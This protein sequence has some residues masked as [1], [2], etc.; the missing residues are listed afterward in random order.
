MAGGS[1]QSGVTENIGIIAGGVVAALVAMIVCVVA[2]CK[3]IKKPVSAAAN[4]NANTSISTRAYIRSDSQQQVRAV[5]LNYFARWFSPNAHVPQLYYPYPSSITADEYAESLPRYSNSHSH[6]YS[7]S[8][9]QDMQL[10]SYSLANRSINSRNPQVNPSHNSATSTT[11]TNVDT[12]NTSNP[13]RSGN[14]NSNTAD[15][16]LVA[17]HHPPLPFRSPPLSLLAKS[18]SHSHYRPSLRSAL[19]SRA[20]STSNLAAAVFGASSPAS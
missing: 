9:A 2:L 13:T 4:A 18:N 3:R 11:Y 16:L 6:S 12:A 17:H 1:K 8:S 20:A 15:P 5:S 14:N 19:G 7:Q 10:P